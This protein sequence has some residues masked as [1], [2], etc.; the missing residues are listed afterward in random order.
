[1]DQHKLYRTITALAE[2]KFKSEGQLLVYVLEKIIEN[3]EIPING[4]RIWKLEPQSGTYRVIKQVGEMEK[5]KQNFR[6]RVLDYPM[7][8]QLPR[9]GTIV[10]TET[11]KYLRQRGIKLYSATGVG[12][13]VRWKEYQLFP[14]V[15]AINAVYL[16]QEM[17][18][19]LNIIGSALTAVLRSKRVEKKAKQLELDLDKAREIQKSILPEHEL[20]FFNYEMYGI[21]VPDRV[22]GGDFFDYL[23]A[24]DDKDRLAVVVG[25][26]ASKGLSAAAQALYV[27]GALRMGVEY[28]TKL[29]SLI[30]RINLLVNKTFT[31]EH[32]VSL[33]YAELSH[34]NNGLVFYV[35]AGHSNPILLHTS[36]NEVEV[37]R[38]TGQL[39][40]P[41][42]NERY[43][44]EFVIMKKG[45][46]LL[47]YT[48][49]ISEA[50]NEKREMYGEDRLKNKLREL[51]TKSPREICQLIIE[52]VQL[53]N[54]LVEYSDDKT[55]V[56]IKRT[57]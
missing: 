10:S 37:L 33:V 47:L 15:I 26:A 25:D 12:E 6:L 22:V 56:V 21:S 50:S 20:K 7:F 28:Q 4:G 38:A 34:S 30:G 1:M 55:V 11:N 27:S 53:H 40:G 39:I 44:T 8:L 3:E 54:R 36:T 31:T 35:N 23:Q 57:K 9:K 13:K 2:Q 45:D 19:A 41:F 16:K 24:S 51:K 46:I 32:F 43:S 48:D 18:Y 52:D 5:I 14:Y 17:I 29:S 49:G 42:P